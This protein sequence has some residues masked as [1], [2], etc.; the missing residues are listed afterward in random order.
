MLDA[1]CNRHT[2]KA[3]FIPN[4]VEALVAS[5]CIRIWEAV[6][7]M[8]TDVMGCFSSSSRQEHFSGRSFPGN[9]SAGT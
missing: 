7:E 9:Y 6:S 3:S 8:A 5:M 1:S 4:K 2:F